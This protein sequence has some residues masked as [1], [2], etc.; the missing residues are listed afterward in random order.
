MIHSQEP[1]LRTYAILPMTLCRP[2]S[3]H[4]TRRRLD[5]QAQATRLARRLAM[6]EAIA[7]RCEQGPRSLQGPPAFALRLR[8]LR[9]AADLRTRYLATVDALVLA[10]GFDEAR[11]LLSHPAQA[12]VSAPRARKRQ[13]TPS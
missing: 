11:R 12:A 3:E 5:L 10:G 7:R 9:R 4:S 6:A 13:E 8:V 1:P 2:V